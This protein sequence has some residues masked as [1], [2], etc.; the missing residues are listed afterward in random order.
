MFNH[1]QAAKNNLASL[2]QYDQSLCYLLQVQT[3]LYLILH[4]FFISFK[5][6]FF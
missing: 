1:A 4:A 2:V 5:L 6:I 3:E